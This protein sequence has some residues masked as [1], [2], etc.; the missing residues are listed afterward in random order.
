MNAL[1]PEQPEG[2]LSIPQDN[3][4]V[5]L[6]QRRGPQ[7]SGISDDGVVDTLGRPD[8][9]DVL[10]ASWSR[11]NIVG[12]FARAAAITPEVSPDANANFNPYTFATQNEDEFGDILSDIAHGGFD[13]VRSEAGF[14]QKARI[15]RLNRDD[16]ETLERAGNGWGTIALRMG[17]SLFD[18]T[19]LVSFGA[20]ARVANAG[21]LANAGRGAIAG[22]ADGL[23]QEAILGSMDPT[24]RAEE[25]WMNVGVQTTLMAGFG[26]LQKHMA[27][28]NPLSPDHPKNPL[29]DANLGT[30][31]VVNETKFGQT[32]DEGVEVGVGDS[33][34]AMRATTVEDS[35]YARAGGWR[36][37]VADSLES[38]L[39]WGTPIARL[40]FYDGPGRQFLTQMVDLGGRLK[41]GMAEGRSAGP[42]AEAFRTVYLQQSRMAQNDVKSIYR[43]TLEKLGQSRMSSAL[44]EEVAQFG[45]VLRPG[46]GDNNAVTEQV[47][48]KAIFDDMSARM[49]NNVKAEAEIKADLK[50]A[51]HSDAD[52]DTIYAGVLKASA[53]NKKM[54]DDFKTDMLQHG[55][56]D[57]KLDMKGDYGLP[58][59]YSRSAINNDPQ[60]FEDMLMRL[61]SKQPSDEFV[62]D[63]LKTLVEHGPDG[64]TKPLYADADALKKDEKAWGDAVKL[65]SDESERAA[66]DAAEAAYASAQVKFAK[67]MD[68]F[69]VI[70]EGI[71]GWKKD[72]KTA[73]LREMRSRAALSEAG[74]HGRRTGYAI[75]RV[76]KAETKLKDLEH[77]YL[78]VHDV[79]DEAHARFEQTGQVL[80][81]T[82]DPMQGLKTAVQDVSALESGLRGVRRDATKKKDGMVR[83]SPEH[84]DLSRQI[85]EAHVE[86]QRLRTERDIAVAEFDAAAKAH[87]DATAFREEM[88]KASDEA[89]ESAKTA[90]GRETLEARMDG[91]K[92]RIDLLKEKLA[93]AE[94]A[95]KEAHDG[96]TASY[97]GK[98]VSAAELRAAAR[99]VRKTGRLN[100]RMQ[101]ATPLTKYVREVT[102]AL[103]GQDRF[104]GGMLMDNVAESG[105]VKERKFEW[106]PDLWKEMSS[107]G[108]VET[109]TQALMDR[110]ARDMGGRLAIQ[111]SLGTQNIDELLTAARD[112]YDDRARATSDPK[113]VRKILAA[114]DANLKDI[115]AAHD[116]LMGKHETNDD[117]AVGWLAGKLGQ[118]GY[119]RFGGGFGLAALG[120]LGT[121]VF[122]QKGFLKGIAQHTGAYKELVE[123][124]KTNGSSQ[125]LLALLQSFET[126]AHM[127]TSPRAIG[128]QTARDHLGFG[129]GTVRDATVATDKLLNVL[130][131][132]VNTLSGLG[133]ISDGTRRIAGFVQIA[134]MQ[135]WLDKGLDA[136]GKFDYQKLSLQQRHDLASLNIGEREAE[137][138]AKLF[139]KHGT[140]HDKLF[141]PGLAGWATEPN[142]DAMIGLFNTAMVKAQQ[143]ASYTQGFGNMPLMMD[144]AIGK[145][146]FQF[147]SQAFQF[148]NNFLIAGMQRGALDESFMRMATALGVSVAMATLVTVVRNQMRAK[149]EDLSKW[150]AAKWGWTLVQR[151]GILGWS[152]Q[153][154]DSFNKLAGESINKAVGVKVIDPGSKFSQNDWLASLVGPWKGV[155][156]NVGATGS[157]LVRG[158]FSKAHE[159]AFQLVPLNQ[160]MQALSHAASAITN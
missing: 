23:V 59:V 44:N 109:D 81:N 66:A 56:L 75:A 159:K 102:T 91:D 76:E 51:G 139:R 118:L 152:G 146:I 47:F 28:S 2:S 24:R 134:N 111:K 143:R 137:Q 71:E 97:A 67:A 100:K 54:L 119:L 57:P 8:G 33:A 9:W 11:E 131:H 41:K 72:K 156:D 104:P 157:S 79:A 14:R 46:L 58:V 124:A 39:G 129:S 141:D 80:S 127:Q 74:F 35:A 117:S 138:M 60:G 108:F 62:D 36:G 22:A 155:L 89:R 25:A 18:V 69:D 144:S 5:A 64:K 52:V 73:T 92:D 26:S 93:A 125:Q 103:R 20:V 27:P 3:P 49:T 30:D 86:V 78:N 15:A 85:D 1:N 148:T 160:Q 77:Q 82:I 99:E 45:A 55:L 115:R 38:V 34:G 158:E 145:L 110:Y 53:R 40:R 48:F 151:T 88:A 116:R 94:K 153:Y 113:K 63:Y 150:D 32:L 13:T 140:Q 90:K 37:K 154:V 128:S 98:K 50:T 68:E 123:L 42:E 43:E 147:Q 31:V 29:R 107:K 6:A 84:Q 106:T 4:A 142:G 105:R 135:R 136:S 7:A 17:A 16:L 130:G 121:A 70:G 10:Q 112:H 126:G 12:Q 96:L 65:W 101:N 120:D 61:L 95:K 114:R 21:R 122:S 19:S 83:G 149:P 87:R 132:K 133:A